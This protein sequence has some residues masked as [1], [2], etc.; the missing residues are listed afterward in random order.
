MNTTRLSYK[1]NRCMTLVAALILAFSI[2]PIF[3]QD[4]PLDVSSARLSLQ[5]NYL[6]IIGQRIGNLVCATSE[7][8][9]HSFVNKLL[10]GG[11]DPFIQGTINYVPQDY[12]SLTM[13]DSVEDSLIG[14]N[15]VYKYCP[16]TAQWEFDPNSTIVKITE[17]GLL[18][19]GE[20]IIRNYCQHPNEAEKELCCFWSQCMQSESYDNKVL[21][22]CHAKSCDDLEEQYEISDH[23]DHEEDFSDRCSLEGAFHPD[24]VKVKNLEACPFPL[25]TFQIGQIAK[26]KIPRVALPSP[27]GGMDIFQVELCLNNHEPPRFGFCHHNS[28][29]HM[30]VEEQS[31]EGDTTFDPNT[32]I[33]SIPNVIDSNARIYLL[34]LKA[35]DSPSAYWKLEFL[36]GEEK[37]ATTARKMAQDSYLLLMVKKIGRAIDYIIRNYHSDPERM[38][39]FVQGLL[40][41][42]PFVKKDIQ[43]I[44]PNP[45]KESITII[46]TMQDTDFV[47]LQW[48]NEKYIYEYYPDGTIRTELGG[49]TATPADSLPA[50]IKRWLIKRFCK[51]QSNKDHRLCSK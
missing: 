32:S 25:Y 26:L 3:A 12:F 40:S 49:G 42:D 7:S 24:I 44:L 36:L 9:V 29:A 2:P 8:S 18:D 20:P 27:K 30:R 14:T 1:M 22:F 13:N 38:T 34:E 39:N 28:L 50:Y 5:R 43:Y 31:R 48:Q 33:V 4:D 11:N 51:K 45:E 35:I 47:D 21:S 17:S 15:I 46:L 6:L 10:N 19:L 37:G 16:K 23:S 41:N